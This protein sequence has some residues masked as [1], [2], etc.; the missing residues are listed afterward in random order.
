V[1]LFNSLSLS[2]LFLQE[3]VWG[4][5]GDEMEEKYEETKLYRIRHSSAHIMAQA[6]MEMFPDGKVTIGPPIEDGFY[7]DFDLPRALTPEDLTVIEKRMR[8]IIA[9]NSVQMRPENF[10]AVNPI[11][12][13]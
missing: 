2:A 8:Q 1:F 5:Q 10:L 11:K 7:Y 4:G 3:R 12:W 13:N 6:V 9:K